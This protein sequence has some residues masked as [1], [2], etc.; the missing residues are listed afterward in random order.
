MP[1][2]HTH[3]AIVEQFNERGEFITSLVQFTDLEGNHHIIGEFKTTM[4]ALTFC[5]SLDYTQDEIALL[6]DEI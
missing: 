3:V 6:E 4:E 5:Q 1:L 2:P